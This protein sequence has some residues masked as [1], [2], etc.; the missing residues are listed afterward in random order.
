V[1]SAN[2]IGSDVI[3]QTGRQTRSV[4]LNEEDLLSA[5]ESCADDVASQGYEERDEF[6]VFIESRS[7]TDEEL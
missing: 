5:A 4:S 7:K 3:R 2:S 1:V 6:D